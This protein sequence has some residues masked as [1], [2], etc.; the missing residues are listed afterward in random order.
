MVYSNA[1]H[2]PISDPN[3]GNETFR[4]RHGYKE[5]HA[6]DA[7]Y[8][9][10]RDFK[11]VG[12]G[13]YRGILNFRHSEPYCQLKNMKDIPR[14]E[15]HILIQWGKSFMKGALVGSVFGYLGFVAGP[16]GPFEMNKLMAAV[17]HRQFSGKYWR[18]IR[19]TFG[20][21]AMLGG[22]VTLTYNL[23]TYWLRHHDEANARAKYLDHQI[24]VTAITT[25]AAVLYTKHPYHFLS[26]VLMSVMI[27]S[28]VTWWF[29]KQGRMNPN[30]AA[31]IFYENT[32]TKDEIE[33]F[34]QQD[35]IEN[36]GITMR[37]EPGYGFHNLTDPK[38]C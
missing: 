31:N 3:Y 29:Y 9:R 6:H 28:P 35:L 26:A 13:S 22:S 27:I 37:S 2:Q 24:A 16:A 1:V 8:R 10:N 34:R 14:E 36:L 4:A 21:G 25:G 38:T 23:I 5:E 7:P 11:P 20:R 18:L 32:A 15:H 30:R 33:R 12:Y 19:N 17:G